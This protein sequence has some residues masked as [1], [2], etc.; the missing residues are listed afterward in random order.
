MSNDHH[1]TGFGLNIISDIEFPEFMPTN[2][3]TADMVI[4]LGQIPEEFSLGRDLST[5][6]SKVSETGYFLN[7]ARIARYLVTKG[8]TILVEP[9]SNADI[10][11]I[12]LFLLSNAMAALLLQRNKI[13]LHASSII[14]EHKLFLFLGESGAGKSSLAA[15]M[16]KRGYSI[17]TDDI[18][19]LNPVSEEEAEVTAV[20]SYPMLKLWDD[21]IMALNDEKFD[22]TYK[23][24]PQN[25]KYG[26]FFHA[27]FTRKAIPIK[28]IFILD[29]TRTNAQYESK[30]ITGVE[31]FE[32]LG[33]N[34]YRRQFI[35]DPNLQK[36][37]FE[38]LSKLIQQTDIYILGRSKNL[39][40]IQSFTDFVEK[41]L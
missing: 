34:T 29:N 22:M 41:Q 1:Y 31:A 17:F 27:D 30:K 20:S 10:Y 40:D 7:I 36:I 23:L 33:K 19:V 35:K 6:F 5:S 9:Y 12:R 38:S 2:F 32:Y 26:Y 28:K 39:G 21:A 11:S 24:R 37:H 14:H 13:L 16:S 15:E 3:E 18:C 8:K 25:E 4:R